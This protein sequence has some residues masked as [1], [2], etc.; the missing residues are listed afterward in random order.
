MISVY[1]TMMC[2]NGHNERSLKLNVFLG[3]KFA[4]AARL[5]SFGV[6]RGVQHYSTPQLSTQA[7]RQ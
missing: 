1:I 4:S 7:R 5:R 6:S 2:P 3:K